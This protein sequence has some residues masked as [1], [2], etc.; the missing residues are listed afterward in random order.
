MRKLMEESVDGFVWIDGWIDAMHRIYA[1]RH[2]H[3]LP[4]REVVGVTFAVFLTRNHTLTHAP[5]THAHTHTRTN[6]TR[7][8]T[9]GLPVC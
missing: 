7:T 1:Y 2:E 4:N 3:I 9:D 5:T 6:H 8:H